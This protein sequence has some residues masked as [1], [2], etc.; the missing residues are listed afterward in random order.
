MACLTDV[1][2]QSVVDNEASEASRQH[3]T[4]CVRCRQR[5]DER[6]ERM[7]EI[8]S[9]LN[10]IGTMPPDVTSTVRQAITSRGAV[11][12]STVLRDHRSRPSWQW[13]GWLSAAATAAMVALVV[14]IVL[15]RFGSPTQLSAAQVLERS[16]QTLTRT[17][18]VE[19]LEYELAVDGAA[20]GPFRITHLI[21]RANPN[22]Y[23]IASY[24]GDGELRTAISQ[25]PT[26]HQRTQAI[27]V[28]GRNYIVRVDGIQQPVLSVPQMAQAL[29]ESVIGMMQATSNPT[30]TVQDGKQ[31]REYVVE[32]P[33]V[34]SRAGAA[35]LDLSHARIIVSADDFRVHEF[36]GT[37]SVLKQPFSVS[38][39]L[40]RQDIVDGSL[41][42]FT[43]EPGPNDVVLNGLPGE[44][45]VEELLTTIIR[46]V[47][48]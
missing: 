37:G 10:T 4:G 38:F 9:A 41:A 14:F 5:V 29:M 42:D 44:G 40:L 19:S 26:T 39:R 47:A 24:G 30:L 12:G 3:L 2:I 46:E 13:A 35:T 15:P 27:R 18:G 28:D 21:D 20:D 32:T 17:T 36:E 11:R 48:R 22:H 16:L 25:D 43:I 23:R 1:D 6:R 33:Q 8:A 45:P 7:E 31:G 34:A